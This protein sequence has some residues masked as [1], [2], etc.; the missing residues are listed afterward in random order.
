MRH[1]L[2]VSVICVFALVCGLFLVVTPGCQSRPPLEE[3]GELEFDV[4]NLPGI[5]KPYPLP[6]GSNENKTSSHD[7][8][9]APPA[10]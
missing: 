2:K 3:L 9:S 8:H 4:P 7:S 1:G 6:G 5:D 10:E